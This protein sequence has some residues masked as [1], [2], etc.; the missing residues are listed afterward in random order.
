[1]KKIYRSQNGVQLL[2]LGVEAFQD[3]S[4]DIENGTEEVERSV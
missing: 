3:N 2:D 4:S 1:M